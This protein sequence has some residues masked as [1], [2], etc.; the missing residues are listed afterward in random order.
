MPE[1]LGWVLMVGGIAY[2]ISTYLT[3]AAP[4]ASAAIE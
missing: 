2:I 4:D 3:Q 1:A